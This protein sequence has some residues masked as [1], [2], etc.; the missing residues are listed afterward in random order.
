MNAFIKNFFATTKKISCKNKDFP[1]RCK[2]Y[3]VVPITFIYW[4][5]HQNHQNHLDHHLNH[6]QNHRNHLNQILIQ[7]R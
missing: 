4:K 1:C 2:K 5:H 3:L 6:H 7:H